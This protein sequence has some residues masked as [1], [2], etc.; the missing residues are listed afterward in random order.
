MAR[1]TSVSTRSSEAADLDLDLDLAGGGFLDIRSASLGVD[2]VV[3][4][5]DEADCVD[6]GGLADTGREGA[7]FIGIDDRR[8]KWTSEWM[9]I[10]IRTLGRYCTCYILAREA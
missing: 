6:E 1:S 8:V 10:S 5:L 7:I 4:M 3:V 9:L 2:A